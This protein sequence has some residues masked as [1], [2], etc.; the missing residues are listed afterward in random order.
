MNLKSASFI[1]IVLLREGLT[2]KPK[3]HF[4]ECFTLMCILVMQLVNLTSLI[5]KSPCAD[6][7]I[8]SAVLLQMYIS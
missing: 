5:P 4:G 3:L 8:Y 2:Q 6:K 7:Y 1:V